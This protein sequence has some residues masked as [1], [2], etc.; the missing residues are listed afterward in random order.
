M[1][2]TVLHSKIPFDMNGGF[3]KLYFGKDKKRAISYGEFSQF[4][5][6]SKTLCIKQLHM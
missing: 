4:L 3:V 6:V 2:K 1:K 5:H